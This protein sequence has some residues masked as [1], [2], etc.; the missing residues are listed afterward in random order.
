MAFPSRSAY[1]YRSQPELCL[2]VQLTEL[3]LA[4]TGQTSLVASAVQFKLSQTPSG[5]WALNY[6]GGDAGLFSVN[7]NGVCQPSIPHP[8]VCSCLCSCLMLLCRTPLRIPAYC[9]S[10]LR[11]L[12]PSKLF[13]RMMPSSIAARYACSCF[14]WRGL[15]GGSCV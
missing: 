2:L 13:P 8:Y 15:D 14:E 3:A 12:F 5:A 6:T 9:R 11:P 1:R 10:L 4:S 7:N